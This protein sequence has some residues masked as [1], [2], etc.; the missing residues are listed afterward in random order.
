MSSIYNTG[1]SGLLA[2]QRQLSTTSHNVAN[3]NTPGYSRQRA[4]LVTNLPNGANRVA[5]GSGVTVT[6]ISR[7]HNEFIT[8]QLR[9]VGAEEGWLRVYAEHASVVD[10]ML[11]DANGGITV[12][13]QDFFKSLQT[14]ADDPNASAT[15]TALVDQAQ[16]L[17]A[18]VRHIA[19][20]LADLET[21]VTLRAK[22]IVGEINQIAEALQKTNQ[23]LLN[24][25]GT[26]NIPP[27]DLLDRRDQLLSELGEKIDLQAIESDNGSGAVNVFIAQGQLLVSPVLRQ[28]VGVGT[29]A[30]DSQAPT[31]TIGDTKI[32]ITAVVASGELAGALAFRDTLI[33]EV[34]NGI[35]RLAVGLTQ[36]FNTQNR[37]GLDQ[38]GD[39]GSDIFSVGGPKVISNSNNTGTALVGATID[40]LNE[41]TTDN[42]SLIFSGG[43]WT[44]SNDRD[45]SS[46]S[47]PGP[48]L[49]LEG[50]EVNV[51]SGTPADGDRFI[52][53]PTEQAADLFYLQLTRPQHIAAA[54]PIRAGSSVAN[55]GDGFISR[56]TL[57]DASN[58][59]LL[60]PIT[61]RFND[62]ATRFDVLNSDT[63]ALIAAAQSYT[64]GGDIEING[65]RVQI[66]GTPAAGD[67]FT[68][69]GN[70]DGVS[71]NTNALAMANL[72]NAGVFDAGNTLFQDAYSELVASVGSDTR[73]ININLQTQQTLQGALVERKEAIS[74]VNLDEEAA[75]LVRFQQAFQASAR[76]ITAAQAVFDSL[77][78]AT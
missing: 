71:D 7:I 48:S 3:I 6:Q 45:D 58:T 44:L 32:D 60:T 12:V 70:A 17:T 65:W 35:G 4:T 42:Y 9:E 1:V 28:T 63:G 10:N 47:G 74:G 24:A 66:S 38:N 72:Q 26:S 37:Q 67:L 75:N 68:V 40:N 76:V 33:P 19:N 56:G 41:L 15:R 49:N 52:I 57:T 22:D 78:R 55:N 77:L 73:L 29:S 18:R 31:I 11:A 16:S 51:I 25:V 64:P 61:L 27:A 43:S 59:D 13:L 69:E 8:S 34:R 36:L 50:I 53:R 46:V 30:S 39:F 62:P 23:D 14:L 5:I 20:R 21:E 2:A 54:S